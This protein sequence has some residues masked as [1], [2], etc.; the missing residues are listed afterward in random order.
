MFDDIYEE[1]YCV[2]EEF[3]KETNYSV[4]KFMETFMNVYI[5]ELEGECFRI[6]GT[7]VASKKVQLIS[8]G[9]RNRPQKGDRE[10]CLLFIEHFKQLRAFKEIAN[11]NSSLKKN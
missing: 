7:S 11:L 1:S 2:A 8:F 9:K 3:L 5:N 10:R 6:M 4:N